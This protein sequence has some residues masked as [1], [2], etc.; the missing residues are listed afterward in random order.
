MFES[1]F[2]VD[3]IIQLR[4]KRTSMKNVSWM[5]DVFGDKTHEIL[6][7]TDGKILQES[8]LFLEKN[9]VER[10]KK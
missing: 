1:Q 2:V 6:R 7:R 3:L 4:K 9:H 5:F 8:E 10:V